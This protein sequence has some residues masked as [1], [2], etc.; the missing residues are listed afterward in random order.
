M[1]NIKCGTSTNGGI[2][3]TDLSIDVLKA[4]RDSIDDAI[5]QYH[6]GEKDRYI[7]D[8]QSAIDAARDAG[9]DVF[10]N[11]ELCEN[12]TNIEM[13]HKDIDNDNENDEDDPI[14]DYYCRM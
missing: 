7:T 9:Y 14:W 8:I 4:M 13:Y 12:D 1:N 3:V 5:R 6:K 10:I 11:D 2:V